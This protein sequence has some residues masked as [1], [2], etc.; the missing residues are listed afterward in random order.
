MLRA[1]SRDTDSRDADTLNGAGG[2]GRREAGE[3]AA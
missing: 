2:G 3:Q 1:G